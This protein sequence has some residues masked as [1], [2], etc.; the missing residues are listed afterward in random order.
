MDGALWLVGCGNM[1]GA[2]VE[3]WR[4]AGFDFASTIVVRPSGIPVAG[5]RT[6]TELPLG[7]PPA[8]CLLGVKPQKLDEVAPRLL[9]SIAPATVLVSMLAGVE[10]ASLRD[11]F[12]QAR[13][14]VRVLPN[15]PVS[16]RRGVLPLFADG[17]PG[18]RDELLAWFGLLGHAFWC[19]EERELAAV[20]SVAGAGPAY[21]AR[22]V[23]A[24]A[25][26]GEER[27]LAPDCAA[28]VALET[29]LGT[30]LMAEAGQEDM[31]SVAR[32]VASPKGTTEAGL[33]VLD[34]NRALDRLVAAT[35]AAAAHRGEELAA[36]ARRD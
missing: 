5:I 7:E 28:R 30:A 6:I 1:A 35:I 33:A 12:P 17:D 13:A 29:V 20:G 19:D 36:L 4:K 27:G 32:R 8:I 16:E 25:A 23:A 2:M 11:R 15:L 9:P 34:Q 21:V 22:F 26:A 31:V 24:L 3:G 18:V 14:I 10:V